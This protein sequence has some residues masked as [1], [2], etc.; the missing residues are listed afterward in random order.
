MGKSV[1]VEL[2]AL[3]NGI[4]KISFVLTDNADIVY[5][6]KDDPNVGIITFSVDSEPPAVV[7]SK[8]AR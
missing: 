7:L 3:G 6:S 2:G 5:D 1:S 8:P 4:H